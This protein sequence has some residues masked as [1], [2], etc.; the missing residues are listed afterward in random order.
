MDI[1]ND[2][3]CTCQIVI[4]CVVIHAKLLLHVW[5]Y[6]PNC[7][8]MCGHTCQIVITCVVIHAKMLLHV[9]SYMPNCYYMCGHT[10]QIVITCVVKHAKLLLHVW[11]Y[12]FYEK[13]LFTEKQQCHKINNI[14]LLFFPATGSE[15]APLNSYP[16]IYKHCRYCIDCT[17]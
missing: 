6:M 2:I 13:T 7:Y 8:Y 9:W 14:I 5:S 1:V 4:T 3:M 10:C 17:D 16:G 15:H 12:D 11:S